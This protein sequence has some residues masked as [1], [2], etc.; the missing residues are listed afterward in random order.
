MGGNNDYN[1]GYEAFFSG[2][3]KGDFPKG[4]VD[5]SY[6]QEGWQDAQRDNREFSLTMKGI[7]CR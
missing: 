2:Y 6:W 7:S 1:L 3:E 5:S 4:E